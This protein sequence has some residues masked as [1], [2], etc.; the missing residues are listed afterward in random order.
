MTSFFS[1]NC[2]AIF[3]ALV[4]ATTPLLIAAQEESQTPNIVFIL[5]DDLGYNEV[6]CYGQTKIRTPNLDRLAEEGMRFTQHYSG[7]P[8]CASSRCVLMTGKHTGH[9]YVRGN[10]EMGGWGP[11]EPEGQLPL[12]DDEVTVAELLKQ[13]GY[14]TGAFGKWG[15]GGPGSEGHPCNQGFDRFYGYLCQRVAHNY[16]PT[17][18]W[19]N[20]DVDVL[21]NEYFSAHQKLSEPLDSEDEYFDRYASKVYAT[22]RMIDEALEFVEENK[23]GPFFL[24]YATPVP[25]VSIQVPR[26]S[27][28]EYA[29]QFEDEPYLGQKSYLP[30]PQPRAGYA[31]M[32]T[33]MDRN[34]GRIIDLID[35]L[36]LTENTLVIFSSD[37]GATFNGG[38]DSE[39]FES[40]QPLRGMKT[41]VFD[42][43][44]RVPTI[45]RWPGHIEPG[46]I[47]HH[48][49]A[50]Q[51]FLPTAAEVSGAES[52]KGIDG[53]SL[54]PTLTGRPDDQP[55]HD[56]LYWEL[57]NNQALRAGD[58]K[59][60]R[61]TGRNQETRTMLFNLKDD[62][63]EQNNL[64][65]S[66]PDELQR[67]LKLIREARVPSQPFPCVYDDGR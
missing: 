5:A 56:V 27:Y 29:G 62:I 2:R 26:D 9:C 41:M 22:D 3:S 57:G 66:H 13:Q 20:H 19:D 51:D 61:L 10:K 8:V 48:I 45:A 63:G 43:G 47:S 55:Q 37:N 7:S 18:L 21:G 44:I 11:D 53:I 15:L 32:V 36:E 25:H 24:Y 12:L 33:R 28:D 42:G 14:A 4:L 6:G 59:L 16:Y 65:E 30:F 38:S 67:M 1:L 31:A 39:Y 35:E 49:S 46:T 34:V 58:W 23:D 64:A 17:H 52:P 54:V 40:N 60:V 50:F